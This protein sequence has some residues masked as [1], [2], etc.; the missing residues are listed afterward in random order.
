MERR[1]GSNRKL[2]P[3]VASGTLTEDGQPPNRAEIVLGAPRRLGTDWECP[4]S[5]RGLEDESVKATTGSDSLQALQLAIQ[6]LRV[7]LEENG[8][9]FLWS[10]SDPA[11]G[12]G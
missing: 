4:F 6:A 9:R 11:F 2:G 5:L 8:R 3:V 10:P 7:L 1:L 12:S